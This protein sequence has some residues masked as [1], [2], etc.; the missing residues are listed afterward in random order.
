MVVRLPLQ[1]SRVVERAA[2]ITASWRIFFATGKSPA[3]SPLEGR[4]QDG[5]SKSSSTFVDIVHIHQI[6]D[7]HGLPMTHTTRRAGRPFT[8]V[9]TKTDALFEREESEREL[10]ERDLRWLTKTAP[11]F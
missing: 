2:R 10:W 8:L 4:R 7:A 3:M 9:L 11:A 5:A 1:D 6:L